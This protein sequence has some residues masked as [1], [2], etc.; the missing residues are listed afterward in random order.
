MEGE[1]DGASPYP[2]KDQSIYITR[3]VFNPTSNITNKWNNN[4]IACDVCLD[5]HIGKY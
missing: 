1:V 5:F 4:E 3:G 2:G